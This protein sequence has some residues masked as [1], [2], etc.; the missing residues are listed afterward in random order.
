MSYSLNGSNQYIIASTT[1]VTAAPFTVSGWIYPTSTAVGHGM[2]G[3]TTA[4]G[5]ASFRSQLVG[6]SAIARIGSFVQS[7]GSNANSTTT[8]GANSWHHII[9]VF[10][11]S[12]SRTVYLNNGG[13]ATNTVSSAPS[14]VDRIV[15]GALINASAFFNY[16]NGYIADIAI[17]NTAL[18]TAEIAGLSK[19]I[20]PSLIRPQNLVFYAPF[21]RDLSDLAQNLSL[22]NNN[23]AT[24]F[25]HPRIYI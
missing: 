3:I 12:T 1:P 4:S 24:A 13:S 17:W 23:S 14:G 2:I 8:W 7:T 21:I 10:A 5:A 15:I 25:S 20:S 9:G 19:S 22:T 18:N 6:T 11:S 16:T